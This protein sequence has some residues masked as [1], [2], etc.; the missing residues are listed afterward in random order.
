MSNLVLFA[1]YWPFIAAE[2]IKL[3]LHRE[4]SGGFAQVRRIPIC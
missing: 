1:K 4:I 2:L 3:Q